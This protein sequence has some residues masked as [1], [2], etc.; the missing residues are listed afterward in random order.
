MGENEK[1]ESVSNTWV[2]GKENKWDAEG[3]SLQTAQLHPPYLQ[4]C[5]G[6]GSHAA[7]ELGVGDDYLW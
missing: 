5:K 6:N 7:A 4:V 2:G 1:L 3:W